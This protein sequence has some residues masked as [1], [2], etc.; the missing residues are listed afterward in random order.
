MTPRSW[1]P[2]AAVVLCAALVLGASACSG[3]A[4]DDRA[5]EPTGQP[6]AAPDAWPAPPADR[7]VVDLTYSFGEDLSKVSGTEKVTFTPNREVCELVFRAW[8]NKP[9]TARYGNSLTVRT[10]K[11]D[12]KDLPLNVSAAGAPADSPGTLVTASL[13]NCSPAGRAV[14][15]SLAFDLTLG[16]RTDERIGYS[17][18][19]RI[20]WM[21]SGYPMLAWSQRDGWVRDA[22]VDV[23]GETTTSEAFELRSLEVEAPEHFAVA[24]IGDA[25]EPRAARGDGRL[26]HRF[27]AEVV[28]DV[29]VTVGE[30]ELTSTPTDVGTITVA[31]PRSGRTRA[32]AKEWTDASR[33]ALEDLSKLLGPV[34]ADHLWVSVLPHVSEGVE[35]GQAIQVGDVDPDKDRWLVVHEFAHLWFYGLVGNNQA[36][37]PW[38]DESF[39]TYAQEIVAPAGMTQNRRRIVEGEVGRSMGQWADQ[40]RA[41]S[42]YVDTTYGAGGQALLD[43]RAAAGPSAF[44]AAIRA[45]LR[46]RAWQI[47]T[48]QDVSDALKGLPRAQEILREA[49]ALREGA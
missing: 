20:A 29:T 16:A 3:E 22:A 49:G 8:P 26:V 9:A 19:E 42:S 23:V 10:V 27:H 37:D 33:K 2:R 13:P 5:S 7:P 1:R 34:P 25:D 4:G 12:D 15:A 43:A 38:L 14:N 40:R 45:Y 48:P 18:R 30:I 41:D 6:T 21:G 35:Y 47:A 28:R 31:L 46:D 39:T 32:D 36:R 17:P 24:A 11:V 44:D